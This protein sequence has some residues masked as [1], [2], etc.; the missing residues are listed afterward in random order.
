MDFES[1][2]KILFKWYKERL[3]K[4]KK[5]SYKSKGRD[6]SERNI[7]ENKVDNEYRRK[8]RELKIKYAKEMPVQDQIPQ[9]NFRY[10][11]GK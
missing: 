8:L 3:D 5:L 11:S 6:G 2:Y 1:E 4:T 10:A 9:S 7:A